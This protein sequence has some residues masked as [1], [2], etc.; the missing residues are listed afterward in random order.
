M[1]IT[2]PTLMA[3][4]FAERMVSRGSGRNVFIGST[5]GLATTRG[6]RIYSRTPFALR[7]YAHDMH[8]DLYGTGVS[9]VQTG[10]VREAGVFADTGLKPPPGAGAAAPERVVDAVL[11]C[12]GG[13]RGEMNVAPLPLRVAAH[14]SGLA[15]GLAAGF[16]RRMNADGHGA[17]FA[18]PQGHLR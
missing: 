9:I 5:S 8:Q 17:E 15:P 16:A 3:R 6:T 13:D 11:S 14:F 18:D 7:G 4:R 10:F 2:S 12:I 1:N